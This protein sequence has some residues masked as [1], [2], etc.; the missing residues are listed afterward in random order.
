M[1]STRVLSW[2]IKKKEGMFSLRMHIIDFKVLL[3]GVVYVIKE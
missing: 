3:C 1:F 2:A